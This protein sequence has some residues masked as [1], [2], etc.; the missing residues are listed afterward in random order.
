MIVGKLTLYETW[1][2]KA[3]DLEFAPPKRKRHATQQTQFAFESARIE[4]RA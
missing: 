1:R 4:R 3:F 2:L